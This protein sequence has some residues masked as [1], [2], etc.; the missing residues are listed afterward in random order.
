MKARPAFIVAKLEIQKS[1]IDK[2]EELLA[3]FLNDIDK[4]SEHIR[5]DLWCYTGPYEGHVVEDRVKYIAGLSE[6]E[7]SLEE[8]FNIEMPMYQRQAMLITLWS[9]FEQ[10]L[11]NAYTYMQPKAN[12]KPRKRG[13]HESIVG[14]QA[15]MLI[16]CGIEIDRTPDSSFYRLNNEV[17]VVRNDWVHNGGNG[18]ESIITKKINGIDITNGRVS[19][20]RSYLNTSLNL[21]LDV[22]GEINKEI[23]GKL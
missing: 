8:L 12:H 11:I 20:S 23:M 9:I 7:F 4:H 16:E 15:E 10:E 1:F 19:L 14:Y 2:H 3:S 5:T 13:K 21:M 18:S 17:R 22:G 6:A